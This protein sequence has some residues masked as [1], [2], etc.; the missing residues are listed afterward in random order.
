MSLRNFFNT[1][2][3]VLLFLSFFFF[4]MIRRPPRSTLFPYTTLFRPGGRHRGRARP[5]R[6]APPAGPRG[7]RR[8]GRGVAGTAGQAVDDGPG[9]GRRPRIL[10]G[11]GRG[12]PARGDT[13]LR[14]TSATQAATNATRI[15]ASTQVGTRYPPRRFRSISSLIFRRRRTSHASRT[16]RRVYAV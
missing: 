11:R 15:S 4:L 8:P 9:P 12:R 2:A 6:G 10:P 16:W 5:A 14:S 3:A 13:Q 7:H 1:R